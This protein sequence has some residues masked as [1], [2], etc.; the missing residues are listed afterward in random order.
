MQYSFGAGSLFGRKL[1]NAAGTAATAPTPV[2]F[3][4]LQDVSIDV[5]F[6]QKELYGQYQFPI[7]LARGA[8]KVACKAKFAQFNA[9]ALND[10]FYGETANP[11]GG[12]EATAVAEAQTV[13]ANVVY[14]THNTAYVRDL[15][16][17]YSANGVILSRVASTPLVGNYSVNETTGTY[18]FNATDNAAAMLVNY[19]WTDG[20]ANGSQIVVTNKLMGSQPTFLAVFTEVSK[21]KRITFTL[22][23]CISSQLNFATKLED[24]TIPEFTFAAFADASGNVIKASFDE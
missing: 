18:T 11:T 13:A 21:G 3:G 5:T 6:T 9:L 24:Y 17:T 23:N 15:G 1:T 7:D 4:G 14:P 12:A 10:L 8:G 22:N 19:N 2:R 16:V 20:T